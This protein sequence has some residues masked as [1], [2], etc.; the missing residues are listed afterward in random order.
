MVFCQPYMKLTH[1]TDQWPVAIL[2]F[3]SSCKEAIME[4]TPSGPGV[5]AAYS[6]RFA[7]ATEIRSSLG[8]RALR[9]I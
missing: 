8:P 1:A 4:S 9:N 7:T 5:A 6:D 2:S 3:H